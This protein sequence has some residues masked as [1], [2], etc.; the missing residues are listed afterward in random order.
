MS[1]K[2]VGKLVRRLKSLISAKDGSIMVKNGA[3]KYALPVE[4]KVV[5]SEHYAF[6]TLPGLAGLY[7]VEGR[8]LK[9]MGAQED[10][11]EAYV[12]LGRE[13][14]ARRSGR[15]RSVPEVPDVVKEALQQIP[16]G[17]R[18]AFDR[19]GRPKLVKMRKRRKRAPDAEGEGNS[20]SGS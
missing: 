18:L 8:Q 6:V 13:G 17:Y 1:E 12:E 3:R 11:S 14:S 4:A 16:K 19:D 2:N 7:R 15:G 5:F 10:A 20:D 9:P